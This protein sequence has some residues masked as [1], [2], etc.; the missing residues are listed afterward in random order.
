MF[1][2]SSHKLDSIMRAALTVQLFL[3]IRTQN[4]FTVHFLTKGFCGET[5]P[6]SSP[7][8]SEHVSSLQLS[9]SEQSPDFFADL[10]APIAVTYAILAQTVTAPQRVSHARGAEN[11]GALIAYFPLLLVAGF[12]EEVA[13]PGA[14]PDAV[15]VN[16]RDAQL[17]HPDVTASLRFK[18][19]WFWSTGKGSRVSRYT[20][21]IP[22][23]EV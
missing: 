19:L 10:H 4:I 5:F 13:A 20:F 1:V 18:G 17:T 7:E 9:H 16:V 23:V 8:Q 15:L 6:C 11:G 21:H 12:A 22:R 14:L 3:A 2:L